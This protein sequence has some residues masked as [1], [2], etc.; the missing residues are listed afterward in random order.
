MILLL[1]H[2]FRDLLGF[3][4]LPSEV[5][6]VGKNEIIDISLEKFF[7]LSYRQACIQFIQND[8]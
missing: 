4:Q 7:I 1:S 8:I 5:I 2:L 6:L 3:S